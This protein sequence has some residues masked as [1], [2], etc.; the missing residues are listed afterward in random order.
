MPRQ[1]QYPG[2]IPPYILHRLIDHGSEWQRSRA[3]NTLTHVR[4]LLPNPGLVSVAGAAAEKTVPGTLQRHIYDAQHLTVLPGALARAE[5][6]RASGDTAV[7]EAYD[8]LGATHDFFWQV[9]GRDSIDNRGLALV[10]T[11]HYGEGYDNA[12]WNGAQMVFGDGDGEVFQRFTRSLDVVAH[13]LAH[14]ITESE[15]GLVYRNQSGALN[16]SVSDVFGILTKQY[17][18]KQTAEQADW[19]IGADLLTDKVK[20]KGLRSMSHPGTAY[21][22]PVLG[23]DPQPAHMRDFVVTQDDNGG[24]H[25]NSGIPNRAFYLGAIA[26]GGSA[27]VQAGQ[28]WYDT[29]CDKRLDNDADF[30]AFATLTVEHARERFGVA[31]GKAVQKAW[32]G[33]GVNLA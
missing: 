11:V 22:D 7:D 20:G 3:L 13:E 17:V 10:G 30:Q 33:V 9:Y 21:D 27:W 24:V 18:L 23:K 15:A 31:Q 26:L 6:Q 1:G 8:A 14:G 32:A 28:I 12:F 5:G 16:E 4:Q 25:L 2:F 19:L 29:V